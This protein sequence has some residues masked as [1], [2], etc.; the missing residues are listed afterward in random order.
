MKRLAESVTVQ[1]QL[2]ERGI[3]IHK[4]K[5]S[6]AMA[7]LAEVMEGNFYNKLVPQLEE[8]IASAGE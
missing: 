4:T 7:P 1:L 6:E 3:T 8:I 5:V 2:L